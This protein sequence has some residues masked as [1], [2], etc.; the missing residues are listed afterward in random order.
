M[1]ELRFPLLTKNQIEVRVGQVSA[2]GCTLLLYKTSRTDAE[3]LDQVVGVGN[4]Q[5]KFY[6]LQGVGVG[7]SVRS[8]VVCSVGI[9]DDDKHEWIWKDDSGTESQVEQDKGVC[10]DAFKRASGGSCWGIGRELYY[11]GFIFAKVPTQQKFDNSGRPKGYELVDKYMSFEVQEISW[12]ENPL[13]LKTLVIVDN[14]GN[15]VFLKKNGGN[16]S[17][18]TEKPTKKGSVEEITK[19][20]GD[21]FVTDDNDTMCSKET[22]EKITAITGT[23]SAERY[24][25]FKAYLKKTF[26]VD[27]IAELTEKQGQKLLKALGGK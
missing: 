13:S 18:T 22:K 24:N 10:S 6:T 21:T 12:Y 16:V 27:S 26:E 11:T 9:Y 20:L 1:K 25:N 23:F 7:D 14:N 3:I 4:W 19:D 8:I 15:V 2:K 5:K 17:Q